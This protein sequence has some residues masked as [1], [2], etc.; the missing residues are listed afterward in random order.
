MDASD[1]K[2]RPPQRTTDVLIVGGG[3]GG[4]ECAKAL[5]H[6]RL[7]VTLVDRTNHHLFQPLLYQVAMAGLSPADIAVPIRSVLGRYENVNVLLGEVVQLDLGA[8]LAVL[9]GGDEI[10]FDWVVIATGAKPNWFG[11]DDWAR[12]ALGLKTVEE[13]LA[14]RH[15]VLLAF[16][17]AEREPDPETRKR[18]LTFV[19]IGGG[20]TGVEIAGALAELGRWVLARD[21]RALR[22][23][24]PRIVLI[25]AQERLLAAG[26]HERLSASARRQLEELGVEVMVGRRVLS[27]DPAG[28]TLEGGRIES[29][30]VIWTAGVRARSLPQKLGVELDRSGQVLVQPDCSIPGHPHAF[31]IGDAARFVPAGASQ[32]LPGIAPVAIQMGHHV[33]R[34]IV[35]SRRGRPSPP[36]HYLDKGIM[37]T[38]GRSRAV[39][40]IGRF[41]LSGLL[42]WLTWTMV[43]I[44]YL[45]GFR[46]RLVVMIDWAWAYLTYGRGA[47]LITGAPWL[48]RQ[49]VARHASLER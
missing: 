35:A 38:I 19:V 45:I 24:Q 29:T 22:R 33:A 14:M 28:V 2:H 49:E 8:K 20:P 4:L 48:G 30:T 9:D 47:R 21:Y 10:R 11:H 23:E 15:R 18:L 46:N 6:A 12:H 27:I 17:A 13:A 25:E 42:A 26:Y 44:L 43:H 39:V 5:G 36:F 7:R 34:A 31:V 32:P 40:Q 1:S 3:F 41:E 16:E 37:A